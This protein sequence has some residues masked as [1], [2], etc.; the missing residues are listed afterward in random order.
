MK[1]NKKYILGLDIST[2]KIGFNIISNTIS[3]DIKDIIKIGIIEPE[4][5]NLFEKSNFSVN[6]IKN[7]LNKYEDVEYIFIEDSLKSF[8]SGRTSADVKIKLITINN[9]IHYEL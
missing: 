7:L 5:N 6:K 1:S 4:G 8:A 3:N 2:S 9:I